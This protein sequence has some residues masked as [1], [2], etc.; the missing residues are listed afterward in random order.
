M[1]TAPHPITAQAIDPT[2]LAILQERNIIE[3]A[4]ELVYYRRMFYKME[5]AKRE[6]QKLRFRVLDLSN[7][8]E[9]C[10]FYLL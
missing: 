7:Q 9:V 1:A 6:N 5:L 8:L 10:F 4:Q 3:I 2:V